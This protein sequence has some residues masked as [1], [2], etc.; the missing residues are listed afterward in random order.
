MISLTTLSLWNLLTLFDPIYLARLCTLFVKTGSWLHLFAVLNI[1]ILLTLNPKILIDLIT[2]IL[3]KLLL[4]FV[5][6]ML[7]V[8]GILFNVEHLLLLVVHLLGSWLRD[9]TRVLGVLLDQ[10]GRVHV[11]LIHVC[12]ILLWEVH[13]KVLLGASASLDGVCSLRS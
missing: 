8:L 13:S 4:V 2:C 10:H 6:D 9:L 7:L 3:L 5:K 11:I 1:V 12:W